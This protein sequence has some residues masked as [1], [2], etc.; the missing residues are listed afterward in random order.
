MGVKKA[1]AGLIVA[2]LAAVAW[3]GATHDTSILAKA[4]KTL[5]V[6]RDVD[7]GPSTLDI[8]R[9]KDVGPRPAIL[10]IHPGGW[11]SGDKA[12]YHA[13]MLE[14]AGLGYVAASANFRAAAFPA[15]LDDLRLA[16][17]RLREDPAVDPS[18]VGVIGW[19]SGAHLAL[20]LALT[21]KVQAAVGFAGVYDFLMET[22]GAFPNS[23]DDPVVM[24]FLGGT[25]RST[26]DRARD[27][28]PLSH[29]TVDDPPLLLLHGEMDRRI[30]VEQ[31]RHFE[32]R[33]KAL[34]RRDEVLVLPDV[35]HGRDVLPPGE[36]ARVR[37][38]FERHLRP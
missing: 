13:L 30:D 17:R 37:A 6:A 33:S 5:A 27:A 9:P 36:R 29:L 16:L 26:P 8:V 20:L 4:P 23:E 2:A 15:P 24:R 1:V 28:S 31:A 21:E 3:L 32:R 10:M 25:P 12:A 19:S 18:R 14:Y 22:R 7:Y 35:D 11:F 34:G 38:F